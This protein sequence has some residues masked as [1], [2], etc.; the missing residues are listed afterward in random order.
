MKLLSVALLG[1]LMGG[2]AA[3]AVSQDA[4]EVRLEKPAADNK[5]PNV[6]KGEVPLNKEGTV[7]LDAKAKKLI[8]KSEVVLRE[9]M[10]EMLLCKRHT[11]E[12]ESI[13]AF[14]GKAYVLHAGLVALGIDPGQPVSFD[15]KYVAPQGRKLKIEVVWTG[16]DGKEHREDARQWIRYAIHR[17]FGEPLATLPAG[18]AIPEDS[19]LRH[20]DVNKELSW[21][22]PMT[23]SQ[24]DKLLALSEDESFQ[25]AIR[26]FSKRSQPRPMDA[27]WVFAG[28]GFVQDETSGAKIYLAE[29][30]D[31][32]CVA[33]F[34]SAM[35]DVAKQSSAEGQEN[36]MFEAWTERLP[37][38]G[39]AVRL[40][41]TPVAKKPT[42][43]GKEANGAA[44]SQATSRP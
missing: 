18:L 35:I 9:G 19:E 38:V 27:D 10:L 15:P 29:S 3:I 28:S 30:G 11:K 41:I 21:Y 6:A 43:A 2:W 32:I 40:E 34:P 13:L 33:N 16:E 22:G 8:V 12:H 5:T 14:D 7:L 24:R 23:E 17:F 37:P 25:T 26:S 1:L 44:A 31:V 36:L 42:D 4:T 20:D 39:T